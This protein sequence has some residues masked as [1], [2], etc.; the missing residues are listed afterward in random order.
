MRGVLWLCSR[1]LKELGTFNQALS[2]SLF[3]PHCA[4]LCPIPSALVPIL[5]TIGEWVGVAL[6]ALYGG[7]HIM[8]QL[9]TFER[10]YE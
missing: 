7:W 2:L 4:I 1:G 6:C 5:Q 8:E 9:S 10:M 3:L